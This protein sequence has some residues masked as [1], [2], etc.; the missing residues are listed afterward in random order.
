MLQESL[1]SNNA[2]I[3]LLQTVTSNRLSHLQHL[4]WSTLNYMCKF[5]SLLKK[6]KP[7]VLGAIVMQNA[8]YLYSLGEDETIMVDRKYLGLKW[9]L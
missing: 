3:I 1:H 7:R 2:C 5:V 8:I 9:F 6:L 4:L